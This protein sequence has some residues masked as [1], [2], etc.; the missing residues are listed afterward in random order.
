MTVTLQAPILTLGRLTARLL[1]AEADLTEV[2]ALRHLAF[3]GAEGLEADPFDVLC[4][5]LVVQEGETL[6]AAARVQEFAAGSDRAQAYAAAFYDLSPLPR[7]GPSLELGRFCLH[8]R[9]SDPAI[10]LLAWALLTRLFAASGVG[11][12]FGCSSF[13]GAHGDHGPGLAAL[14]DH[15][16]RPAPG[17]RAVEVLPLPD[18]PPEPAR[19][20]PLLRFYLGLGAKVSDHAVVDRDLDTLHVLTLLRVADIPPARLRFLTL[21]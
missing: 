14:R 7:G 16:A 11:L 3:R 13:P 12:V 18:L 15:V 21:A 6:V 10:L 20:P 19:L 5:H 4:R 9:H 17:R 2:R 1:P 8:P